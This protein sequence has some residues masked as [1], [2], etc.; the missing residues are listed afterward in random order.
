MEAIRRLARGVAHDFNNLLTV[1]NGCSDLLL[2]NLGADDQIY[3]RLTEIRSAG[4]RGQELTSQMLAFSRSRIRAAEVLSLHSVIEEVEKML[5][6]I[7]GDDIELVTAFEPGLGKV[8]AD[9]T[10]LAQIL[11]NLAVN[12]RDAMPT[13]GTLTFETRNVDVDENYARNHPA[14]HAG[15]YVLLTVIDT[16]VGM[17]AET[18]QHLFEPFFTTKEAGKGTGLGLATVYGI[19]SQRGGWIRVDSKPREGA[20]FRIYLPR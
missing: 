13:G 14:A 8:K 15:A 16:G 1:I 19:V 12:A 2:R 7:I 20:T 18:Q 6:R 4:Q 10:E 17:D 3:A 9:R 5:R 11:L